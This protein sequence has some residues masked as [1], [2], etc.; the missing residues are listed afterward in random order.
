MKKLLTIAI[1]L[2]FA[3]FS[4]AQ[5]FSFGLKGGV[6]SSKISFDD[7]SIDGD[8]TVKPEYVPGGPNYDDLTI[9]LPDGTV[10]INP[11]AINTP[12]VSFEPASYDVGFHVGAFARIKI[13]ALFLQ[14]ELIFSQTNANININ[15]DGFDPEEVADEVINSNIKYNNFDIPILLGI[16]MGP[17]HL[18]V[19]PVATFKLSSSID[20]E[21]KKILEDIQREEDISVFTATKNATFGAQVGAGVTIAKKVTLDIRYEFGLSKL[22]ESVTIGDHEFK[23]DQRQNQFLGSI[24]Y[25]F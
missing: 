24:G 10:I 18:C 23:T 15:P 1:L 11:E 19:G 9:E 7:F 13:A 2:S 16:K 8:F 4:Q 5:I 14:P 22:G 17:A 25:I 6:N 20:D 12:S 21:T 3:Y